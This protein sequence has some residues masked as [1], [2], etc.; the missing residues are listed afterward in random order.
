[1]EQLTEKEKA[2]IMTCVGYVNIGLGNASRTTEEERKAELKVTEFLGKISAKEL[3]VDINTLYKKLIKE[4]ME[5][6]SNE[7]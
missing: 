1:M 2:L 5:S 3:G 6:D 4:H 7:D